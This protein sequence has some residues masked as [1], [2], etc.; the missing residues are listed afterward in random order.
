MKTDVL[1]NNEA[2]AKEIAEE[3]KYDF[4]I[5]NMATD[6]LPRMTDGQ[7]EGLI[8]ACQVELMERHPEG[9]EC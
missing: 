4:M 2:L 1:A 3:L 5:A 8:F 6:D 9:I 7:I